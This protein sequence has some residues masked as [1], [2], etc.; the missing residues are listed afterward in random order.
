MF[1]STNFIDP[2]TSFDRWLWSFHQEYP[3]VLQTNSI[4]WKHSADCK[5]SNSSCY[6]SLIIHVVISSSWTPSTVTRTRHSPNLW[7]RVSSWR[8]FD[9]KN[10]HFLEISSDF[11][12]VKRSTVCFGNCRIVFF[13]AVSLTA[14]VFISERKEGLLDRSYV[15][16]NMRIYS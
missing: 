15:A 7:L 2:S 3:R 1:R 6:F 13:I 14:A 9:Y 8:K 4:R 12:Y 5:L 16:G 11:L 10:L